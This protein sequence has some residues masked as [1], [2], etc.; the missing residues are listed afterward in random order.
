M[1]R[2]EHRSSVDWRADP[3]LAGYSC[4]DL[5]L[6]TAPLPV[7]REAVDR[8]TATLVR[9]NPPAQRRAVLYLHG[10]NDYFFQ[11][12]VADFWHEQGYDFHALDLRRY[13]R[14]LRA[15][16]LAGWI[17][18]LHD[19]FDEL[20]AAVA[21]IGRTH[22]SLVL[23][24]HS[25][26][27]LVAALY[28]DARPGAIAALVLNSPWLDLHGTAALSRAVR[29][30]YGP[31]GARR[32]TSALRV[33]DNGSYR[34]TI[35]ARL[36]GEWHYDPDLK[37]SERFAM[38]HG[39]MRAIT[40][41]HAEVQRGLSIDAPVLVAISARSR[42]RRAAPEVVGAADTVLDVRRLSASAAHLGPLVTLARIE[43]GLHDLALSPRPVREAFFA[44]TARWLRAYGPPG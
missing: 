31:L 33:P 13:G 22:D 26:G 28:A 39:W 27:G 23:T 24:G 34:S 14:S 9:R 15:G 3:L 12:H 16:M 40:R 10:W 17:G 36:G 2:S 25:T 11:T 37:G 35:D 29:L 6:D 32:P 18:D 5:A 19:Y 4:H 7:E 38:W 20:D 41:G 1:S 44:E 30:A 21:E 42:L 8:L 43:G